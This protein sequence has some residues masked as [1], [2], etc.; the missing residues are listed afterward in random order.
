VEKTHILIEGCRYY[1]I[2]LTEEQVQQ[3]LDYYEILIEWNEVMN[4]TAITDFD[5]VMLKHFVDSLALGKALPVKDGLRMIDVGTGAG[6]PGIPLKIA[7]PN[8]EVV[9]LDSLNKRVKFLN[10]VIEKLGLKGITAVHGRAEDFARQAEYRESFDVSV[11][12]AVAN[13]ASLSEYCIP[14]TKVGG[15]FVPYKSGN[16]EEEIKEGKKAVQIL[17]GEIEDI[18]KFSLPGSDIERSLVVIKKVKET[19]KKYPRKAGLPSKEPLK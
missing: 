14:Y 5:E 13:M 16:I 3:F 15:Y 4:L 17:G 11:S 8:L 19:G 7:Y 10:A 12:R 6:F 9:L 2:E 18:I 1:G